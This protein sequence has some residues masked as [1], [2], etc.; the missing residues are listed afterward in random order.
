MKQVV[1]IL[2]IVLF[3]FQIQ[4]QEFSTSMYFESSNGLKDTLIL[5]YD[6]SATDGIDSAFSEKNILDQP[7]GDFDIRWTK[8]RDP[9]CTGI[10][11][12]GPK[13]MQEVCLFQNKLNIVPKNCRS[14]IGDRTTS[15]MQCL[16]PNKDLPVKIKWD[17]QQFN[18]SC[19][20]ESVVTELPTE[21]WWDILCVEPYFWDDKLLVLTNEVTIPFPI[22]VQVYNDQSDTFSLLFIGL[23]HE[24]IGSNTEELDKSAKPSIYPNPVQKDL[25]VG[26]ILYDQFSIFD[27]QGRLIKEGNFQS[28]IDMSEVRSGVYVLQLRHSTGEFLTYKFL[29]R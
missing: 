9:I 29:K 14:F 17:A 2:G 1:F 4:A 10:D 22:G 19:L 27:H 18:T 26:H 20:N 28:S 8:V 6:P 11:G 3:V 5:G 16:I 21:G 24:D 25:Q 7:F 12:A 13:E 23:L 15:V